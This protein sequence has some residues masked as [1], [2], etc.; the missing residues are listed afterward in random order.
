MAL[1]AYLMEHKNN[2]GPAP[3]HRA[4]RGHGQLEDRAEPVAARRALRLLC[5]PQG[6]ARPQVRGRGARLRTFGERVYCSWSK[7]V[8]LCVVSGHKEMKARQVCA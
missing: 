7:F 4:Q 5:G 2:Y 3:D 8:R 6:G 1:I